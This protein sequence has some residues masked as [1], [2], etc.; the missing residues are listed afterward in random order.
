MQRNKLGVDA[1]KQYDKFD[2][3]IHLLQSQIFTFEFL[4]ELSLERGVS[5]GLK[6]RLDVLLLTRAQ[7][8][9]A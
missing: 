8:L 7:N 5:E 3:P 1:N 9:T 6:E 2:Q 4:E